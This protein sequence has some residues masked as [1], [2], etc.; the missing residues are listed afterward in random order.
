MIAPR[1]PTVYW[2]RIRGGAGAISRG[3]GRCETR[4]M[5]LPSPPH[6]RKR[7]HTGSAGSG[8]V[9]TL[10]ERERT[11][12][13]RGGC[14]PNTHR[15]KLGTPLPTDSAALIPDVCFCNI[16]RGSW[17]KNQPSCHS[18]RGPFASRLP[19]TVP[20]P[21]SSEDSPFCALVPAFASHEPAQ[22]LACPQGR[23][24]DLQRVEASPRGLSR[25]STELWGSFESPPP[26]ISN[27]R[28]T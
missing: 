7:R 4:R 1:T 18:S 12:R 8:L 20:K 14:A 5:R 21:G 3:R 11:F 6:T 28:S 26:I 9:D 25:K 23:P 22:P 2:I 15:V 13:D 27:P 19:K 17:R 16:E 24:T 10:D